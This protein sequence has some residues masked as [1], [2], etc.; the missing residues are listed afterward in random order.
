MIQIRVLGSLLGMASDNM[1]L[2]LELTLNPKPETPC[3]IYLRGSIYKPARRRAQVEKCQFL[4]LRACCVGILS[5]PHLL[6]IA[7]F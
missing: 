3:S 6:A 7:R 5:G 4:R 2:A 1:W